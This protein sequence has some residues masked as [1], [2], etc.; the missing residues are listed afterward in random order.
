M[1]RLWQ[2]LTIL[3]TRSMELKMTL[4][5]HAALL[6][7]PSSMEQLRVARHP[8]TVLS[9]VDSSAQPSPPRYSP[10]SWLRILYRVL[11]TLS[12]QR[13]LTSIQAQPG[14]PPAPVSANEGHV[15]PPQRGYY[16][17]HITGL[18]AAPCCCTRY[19]TYDSKLPRPCACYSLRPRLPR[20]TSGDAASRVVSSGRRSTRSPFSTGAHPG[21]Q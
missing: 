13:P 11:S 3:P 18:D 9:T 16:V 2:A 21:D 1:S 5:K 19:G 17:A 10:T 12:V 6:A 20:S 8:L 15:C 7:S 4:P 14:N